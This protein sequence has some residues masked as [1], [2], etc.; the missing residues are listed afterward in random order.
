MESARSPFRRGTQMARVVTLTPCIMGLEQRQRLM[1]H[2]G[3]WLSEAMTFSLRLEKGVPLFLQCYTEFPQRPSGHTTGQG[4][5]PSE[6]VKSGFW[7]CTG[8]CWRSEVPTHLI[9]KGSVSRELSL[10]WH[11]AGW[12]CPL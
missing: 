3:K 10:R 2:G 6:L 1:L 7:N 11:H 5:C 9:L 12:I 4:E 8:R